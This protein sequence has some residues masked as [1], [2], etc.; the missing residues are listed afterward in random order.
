MASRAFV[1]LLGG[2]AC[3]SAIGTFNVSNLHPLNSTTI[4]LIYLPSRT[5]ISIHH[6]SG[7]TSSFLAVTWLNFH[8]ISLYLL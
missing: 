8:F 4:H 5:I 2:Q 7:D 1:N 3:C 6:L